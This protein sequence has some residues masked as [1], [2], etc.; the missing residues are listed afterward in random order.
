MFFVIEREAHKKLQQQESEF[1]RQTKDYQ[2]I[3]E[4]T[5]GEDQ[6]VEGELIKLKEH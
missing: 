3:L 5:V 2:E 6:H 1:D 4:Q